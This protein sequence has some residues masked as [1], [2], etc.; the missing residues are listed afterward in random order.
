MSQ[1]KSQ[2][3]RIVLAAIA[4]L[5]LAVVV[6]FGARKA[7]ISEGQHQARTTIESQNDLT[8]G[9]EQIVKK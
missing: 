9:P 2:T 4:F 5:L 7:G 8:A 6:F 3:P 1:Q